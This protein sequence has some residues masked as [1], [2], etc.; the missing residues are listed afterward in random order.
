M[1]LGHIVNLLKGQVTGRVESGFPE[2]VL[3]ICA[4]YGVVFW[5][6][7]WESPVSFTFSLARRDWKRLRRLTRNLDCE[8]IALGWKGGGLGNRAF[9]KQRP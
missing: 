3:N 9:V 5:D 6:L 8:L 4:E 7:T 2:R 1:A